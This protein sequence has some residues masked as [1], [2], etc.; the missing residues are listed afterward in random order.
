MLDERLFEKRIDVVIRGTSGF[1][2]G[3]HE[4]KRGFTVLKKLPKSIEASVTVKLGLYHTQKKI[5]LKYL[6]PETTTEL[7]GTVSAEQACPIHRKNGSRVVIIGADISGSMSYVGAYGLI[8][9][10]HNYQLPANQVC[11]QLYSP[12]HTHIYVVVDNLCRSHPINVQW[13]G[14]TYK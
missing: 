12:F 8:V 4:G 5:P 11:V 13:E 14:Y 10:G 9:L 7:E 2:N 1:Q 3:T 6:H